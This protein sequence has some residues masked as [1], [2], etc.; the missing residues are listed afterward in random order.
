MFTV[1][2]AVLCLTYSIQALVTI[3]EIVPGP[4]FDWSTGAGSYSQHIRKEHEKHCSKG[5]IGYALT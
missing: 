3:V 1:G 2:A 5:V 4:F